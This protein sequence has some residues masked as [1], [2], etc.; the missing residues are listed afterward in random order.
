MNSPILQKLR[1]RELV[2][3]SEVTYLP[4][5]SLVSFLPPRPLPLLAI[6]TCMSWVRS[7]PRWLWGGQTDRNEHSR[8]KSSEVGP[9]AR[10]QEVWDLHRVLAV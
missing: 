6:G 3:C 1:F 4:S 7:Q 10:G 5:K 2:T 8:P 9:S